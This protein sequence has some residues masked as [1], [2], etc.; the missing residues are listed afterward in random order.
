MIFFL[1]LSLLVAAVTA[2]LIRW[3]AVD[4]EEKLR[5]MAWPLGA[6]LLAIVLCEGVFL[7]NLR[8]VQ[9]GFL[10]QMISLA[11][12]FVLFAIAYVL[13]HREELR[14]PERHGFIFLWMGLAACMHFA[15]LALAGY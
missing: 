7:L 1:F 4:G 8:F 15:S 10:G 5:D 6:G 12:W 2:L 11:E 13:Y 9:S 3:L 14:R